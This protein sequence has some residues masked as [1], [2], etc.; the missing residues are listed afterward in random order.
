MAD[1]PGVRG[2]RPAFIEQRFEPSGGAVEKEGFDSVGH[3]SFYHSPEPSST[4][5]SAN[6]TLTHNGLRR[7]QRNKRVCS[8]A[9]FAPFA[10][11]PVFG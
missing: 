2:I 8:F 4:P 7:T 1:Q 5:P 6:E 3:S 9:F 10:G 11:E